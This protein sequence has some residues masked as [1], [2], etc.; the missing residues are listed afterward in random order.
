MRPAVDPSPGI[1]DNRPPARESP[2][3]FPVPRASP[4]MTPTGP[5]QHFGSTAPEGAPQEPLEQ[6]LASLLRDR[7]CPSSTLA[8]A[9][10]AEL[11]RECVH[12]WSAEPGFDEGALRAALE[13]IRREQGWRAPVA[14]VLR[15]LEDAPGVARVD[16]YEGD[17]VRHLVSELGP[18]IQGTGEGPHW[19]GRALSPGARWVTRSRPLAALASEL[20]TGAVVLVASPSEHV[21]ACAIGLETEVTFVLS[22]GGATLAGRSLAE[23]LVRGGRRVRFVHDAALPGLVGEADAV[24]FGTEA[25]G[26]ASF[27]APH[28]ARNLLAEAERLGVPARLLATAD[29]LMPGGSLELPAWAE[30]EPW[31]LWEDAPSRM[32]LEPQPFEL[33]PFDPHLMVACERGLVRPAELAVGALDTSD[34]TRA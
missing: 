12:A 25:V 27:L 22:Q 17:L 28:G 14:R 34:L 21:E 3:P 19:S 31:R 6:R 13:P 8:Q 2:D 24:W 33:C 20:E 11:L 5:V 32:E 23:N 30:D 29:L 18:W 10:A 7:A 1:G 26:P 4:P 15:A 9:L 16:G